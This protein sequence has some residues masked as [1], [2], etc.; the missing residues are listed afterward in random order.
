MPGFFLFKTV[1]DERGTLELNEVSMAVKTPQGLVVVVGCSHP[2]IERILTE[3]AKIDPKIYSVVG[4]LHLVNKTEQQVTEVVNNFQSK[5]SMQRVAA[6]HCTGPFA[7]VEMRRLFGD[8]FDH[9][10]LGEAIP[11][12][13]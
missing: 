4:G 6:G 7:Q 12:P 11:L 5:W 13:K 9:S 1:S 3:A 8:R 2:G 10:G